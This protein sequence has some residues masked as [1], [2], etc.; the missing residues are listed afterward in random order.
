MIQDSDG[1]PMVGDSARKLGVR[2]VLD[3]DVDDEA[4]VDPLSG[5]MSASRAIE[6]LP[7]HRRPREHGG[8]G[9]DP[10]WMIDEEALPQGLA[11]RDDDE[12]EGH[13]FIEPAW[14]MLLD[15]YEVLLALT[16]ADWR[17]NA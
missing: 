14:R 15:D 17:M 1:Q 6:H 12:L 2:P 16:R 10:L 7:V 3:I 11:C 13:V 9:P 5:G 4:M 8:T